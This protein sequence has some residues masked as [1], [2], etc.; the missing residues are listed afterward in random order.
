MISDLKLGFKLMK[1]GYAAKL[2]FIASI[3]V[4]VLGLLFTALS[5]LGQSSF[6]GGYFIMMSALFLMQLLGTVNVSN[7]VQSSPAKKRL[8]TRIPALISVA[9]MLVGHLLNVISLSA[10]ACI[11]PQAVGNIC[12]Q[13]ILTAFIMGI[14]ILYFGICFKKFMLGTVLFFIV[15]F[16]AYGPMLEGDLQWR[17]IPRLSPWG[18]LGLTAV[19]G[20]AFILVCGVL[21]YLISLA[22]FKEPMSKW[23]QGAR[24]RKQM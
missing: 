12:T 21:N 9:L 6:P 7:L 4:M 19:I 5:I 18:N 20:L 1:Y 8:Q 13:I 3:V 24:L 23:A 10:F 16:S 14:V 17:L 11:W 2:S 22:L 15:F